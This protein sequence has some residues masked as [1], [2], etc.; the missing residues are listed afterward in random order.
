MHGYNNTDCQRTVRPITPTLMATA[1]TTGRNGMPAQPLIVPCLFSE[2]FHQ[3]MQPQVSS[4]PGKAPPTSP[5]F[6]NVA[7]LLDY[8][9]LLS[10]ATSPVRRAR[11]V[12]RIRMR[13]AADRCFIASGCSNLER[14]IASVPTTALTLEPNETSC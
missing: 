8:R 10:G 11:P 6:C 7:L 4:L 13:L 1:P 3:P 14:R 12:L 9:S 5:I 2:C